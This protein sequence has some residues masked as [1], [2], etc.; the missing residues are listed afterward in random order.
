MEAILKTVRQAIN[1]Q[2]S[3]TCDA[4]G[5]DSSTGC[6]SSGECYNY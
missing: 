4:C 5:G 3:W 2:R 1:E 6:L